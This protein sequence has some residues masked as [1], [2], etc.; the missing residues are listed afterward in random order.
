MINFVPLPATVIPGA[1]L[2]HKNVV[3]QCERAATYAEPAAPLRSPQRYEPGELAGLPELVVYSATLQPLLAQIA[4]WRDSPAPVLITG[5]TG[6]GKELFARAV[7]HLSPRRRQPFIPCNCAAI[8]P[9]LAESELFGHRRGSF[10]GA[11]SDHPGVIGAADGGTL[12]LDEIGELSAELQAKLLRFLQEGEAQPVGATRPV[13]VNVRVIALTN[14]DLAAEVHAGRFRAD[15]FYRLNVL[16]LH[17]PPLRAE[18]GRIEPLIAHYFDRYRQQVGKPA[19]QLSQETVALL[20]RYEWPG[21]VRELCNELQRLVANAQA[22][23]IIT[24]DHLSPHVR[25]GK[26][27]LGEPAPPQLPGQIVIN[28]KQSYSA[29][30]DELSRKMIIEALND[31]AGNISQVAQRL[32]MD[33]SGLTKAIKRLRIR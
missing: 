10:T 3:R 25:E 8:N 26:S 13:K 12:L 6:T 17:L 16:R 11:I 19:L 32:D 14:R 31:C 7:H 23:A 4:Q 2:R 24:A 30:H 29:A 1:L 9:A 18:Q 5:E 28:A 22:E 21:N 20:C 15:L 27:S 33:R